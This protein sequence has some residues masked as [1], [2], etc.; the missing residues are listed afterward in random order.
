MDDETDED[1]VKM[2]VWMSLRP[3]LLTTLM[4]C[5]KASPKATSTFWVMFSTGLARGV[6]SVVVCCGLVWSGVV[7]C[8]LVWCSHYNVGFFKN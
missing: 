3:A 7:W 2:E 6:W 8:G 5:M 1:S 4:S